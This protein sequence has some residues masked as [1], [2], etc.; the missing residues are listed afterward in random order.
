MWMFPRYPLENG[1]FPANHIFPVL[2]ELFA[3][4]FTGIFGTGDIVHDTFDDRVGPA[5]EG[6]PNHVLAFHHK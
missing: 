1:N 3:D 4:Y 6:G 2:Y 5:A